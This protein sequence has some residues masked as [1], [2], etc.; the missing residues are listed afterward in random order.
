[1]SILSGNPSLYLE[2]FELEGGWI[3]EKQ[4]PIGNSTSNGT[5]GNFTIAYNVINKVDGK[6]AFLKALDYSRAM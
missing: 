2:G 6:R 1:M 5:G 4:I 3:V